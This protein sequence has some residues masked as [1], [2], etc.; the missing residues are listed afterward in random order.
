MIDT[1]ISHY[2]IVEKLGGGGMGVVYKA[3]DTRLHRFVALKFLPEDVARDPQALA[4]FQRE[5]QAASALN[6]PNICTIYDIGEQ[7][8]QAFIAMEFLDGM[9]LK[10][11]IAGRPLDTDLILSLAIEI[12]DAL[13]A[14]HA[15]GIVH[16]DIKPANIFVTKRGHAKIMDFGLAKVVPALRT[17]G[18]AGKTDQ[19][20]VTLEQHLTS[21][22]T[23]IGT[24]AYMSPEQVRGKELDPRT[25]LF[26][27]GAVMYEMATGALPFHGETS[28]L[29]FK[30]IL[31]SDPPPA[32]RFNRQIPPKLEDII[33]RALEKDRELRYQSA[34]EM[35]AE[36]QRLKR[37]TESGHTT[38]QS[39][40]APAVKFPWWRK[41][42]ALV[43]GAA[44]ATLLLV[45]VWF[46]FFRG[47][48]E[49][50]DSVAV[51]PFANASGDPNTEYLSDGI[52]ESIINSLSQLPNLRVMARSTVFHYKG[53]ES[54]P[55]KVGHE[56][57]V[58]AVLAGRLLQRGDTVVV[59]TEL[60]DVD[61]GSQLWG[62]QYNRKLADLFA[63]QEDISQEIS[64]KLRLRLTG[65]EKV[66]LTERHVV[67]PEAYQLYLKGR[68]Y[69]NK[70]TEEGFNKAIE[71]FDQ[72]IEKDPNYALAHAGLADS[73]ILLGEYGLLPPSE[74]YG[75]A[76]EAATR[77]LEL[78]D[79]L[80]E[81]HNAL[82][83]VKANY[84]WDWPGAE[85]EYKRA[86][87]LNP[88]YATA[89]QWYSEMLSWLGR[90]EEALAE[91]KRAQQLDPLSLIINTVSGRV[92]LLA[93]QNDLAIEQLRKTLE[94]DPN[95]AFAHYILGAAYLR[96]GAFAEAIA[97]FQG[98]TTL[99]PNIT[100]YK[101]GL[102]Y[103]YGRAGKSAE[104]RKLLSE[105]EEL[106]RRRYVSWLD[107]E[108]IYAGLGEK[109]QAFAFLEKAYEQR[110]YRLVTGLV[111]M[112]VTVPD[113]WRSD[114]RFQDLLRRVGLPP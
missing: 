106:S 78:D 70:R 49:A 69:W 99:S 103:A 79:T 98:A 61:K 46:A 95:F 42:V 82:A 36:L 25:D 54:D 55:Q 100:G 86:I 39:V 101:A 14:A 50:I 7:D 67:N 108:A 113:P 1:T 43:V 12:S 22:G 17:V 58:R 59:Q 88:G 84:D 16:R 80:G 57:G 9:T 60:V 32:I 31:D 20:T 76:R 112:K 5:A 11:K 53:K 89:H 4:R 40:P 77:A 3:E 105:L 62:E 28:A 38:A 6:H 75:K 71:D 23:A 96:K 104:A 64:E 74:A 87:E 34:K 56:L 37:D 27:F 2:L 47:R 93:G 65:E 90:H 72:A 51:L 44:L 85:R 8:G 13:D 45:T 52:S 107:F 15:E 66:R 10:H 18:E 63:I 94:M 111:Y 81:A 97:E 33:N 48:G 83:A 29:I 24:V 73:Y 114:P 102:G 68:Y 30:A 109:D 41:K 92:L 110:D 19:L 35:R 26:S 91:I 21:P